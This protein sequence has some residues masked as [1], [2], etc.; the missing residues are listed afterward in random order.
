MAIWV[1]HGAPGSYKT[2]GAIQRDV[3]PAI[4]EGRHIITNVRGFS[5]ARVRKC[6]PK[7]DIGDGFK[8][9]VLNNDDETDRLR[10]A[11][12]FHWAEKGAFFLVDEVQRIW[13]PDWSRS[14]VQALDFPGGPQ[15]ASAVNRPETLRIAFDMHRH[16]N[17]DFVLTCPNIKQ[18]RNEIREP[19]ETAIRHVNMA[20]LGF[21]GFYKSVLHTSD[22]SGT[23]TSDALQ[24]KAFNR[25]KSRIFKLYDSTAT[26][27]VRDSSAGSS[28]LGDPKLLFLT[29]FCTLSLLYGLAHWRSDPFS[30]G[31]VSVSASGGSATQMAGSEHLASGAVSG[32]KASGPAGSLVSGGVPV[33]SAGSADPDFVTLRTG[34][35]KGAR[36]VITGH[37]LSRNQGNITMSYFFVLA[38]GHDYL[39]IDVTD[40]PAL[41]SRVKPVNDCLAFV[42]YDGETYQAYCDPGYDRFVD[43]QRDAQERTLLAKAEKVVAPAVSQ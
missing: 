3:L 31:S 42:S 20:I 22:N 33:Q 15:A 30:A 39:P 1:H 28:M 38:T 41:F 9:T 10:M 13:R 8:V 19:A 11:S 12:F 21:K 6:L 27:A 7:S 17:W 40:Y 2:S 36:L 25:V 43:Q 16:H 4:K 23:S 26:G 24:V 32:A 37:Q 35:F 29:G 18:V 34:P 14:D 5:E